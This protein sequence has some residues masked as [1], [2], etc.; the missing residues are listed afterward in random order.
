MTITQSPAGYDADTANRLMEATG[1]T[2]VIAAAYEAGRMVS[3]LPLRAVYP[4]EWSARL[5]H[6]FGD[7]HALCDVAA[8][9]SHR[10]RA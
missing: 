8:P 1:Q 2:T 10:A 4:T 6:A 9:A 7:G 3:N 5:R